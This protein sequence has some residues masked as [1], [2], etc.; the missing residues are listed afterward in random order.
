MATI[1]LGKGLR[2]DSLVVT[3]K[4]GASSGSASLVIPDEAFPEIKGTLRYSSGGNPQAPALLGKTAMGAT[5]TGTVNGGS[6]TIGFKQIAFFKFHTAFFAGI[7][8]SDGCIEESSTGL[9]FRHILDCAVNELLQSPQAPFYQPSKVAASGKPFAIEMIDQPAGKLR[10]Q[11]RNAKRDRLNFLVA[12][13][14]RCDFLCCVVVEHRDGTTLPLEGFRWHYNHDIDVNWT[15]GQPSIQRSAASVALDDTV[16]RVQPGTPEFVLLANPALGTA[17][18]IV[19]RFNR[20][21]L[22]AQNRQT[23]GD[24]SITEFDNYTANITSDMQFRAAN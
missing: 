13:R 11:R 23:N 20:A 17:D 2:V 6:V 18:T 24:Y 12:Y 1:D 15:N 7:K 3:P 21:M 16:D 5:A 19:T 9:N 4:F 8:D 10:L 14:S 22:A